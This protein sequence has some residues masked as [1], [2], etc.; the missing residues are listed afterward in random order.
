M[1]IL[2]RALPLLALIGLF[3]A[4]ETSLRVKRGP[5]PREPSWA[6][7]DYYYTDIYKPFFVLSSAGGAVYVSHRER[8]AAQSFPAE[9]PRDA[10]RVFVL[11]GS[12]ALSYGEPGGAQIVFRRYLAKLFPGKQIELIGCGMAGYDSYRDAI[13]QNEVLEHQPDAVV[14]M[15]GNNE[16]FTP[17]TAS[18]AAYRLTSLLRKL[19]VLRL[20]VDR[21]KAL[22]PAP[23]TIPER[24]AN[25]E[26][27]LRLM[28]GRAKEKKV[29]MIFCTLP[30]NVR[31]LPPLQSIPPFRDAD[32]FAALEELDSGDE[33][34]ASRMFGRY[35]E[36]HP[37]EP[38]G[39]Y[40]LARA[41]ERRK[42]FAQAR[43]HYLRAVDL[44]DPG[45]RCSPKRN[46][47]IRRVAK[48]TGMILADLDAAFNGIAERGLPD[49]RI[50]VDGC[51]WRREYY[52]LASWTILRSLDD[53]SRPGAAAEPAWF[54][55]ERARVLKPAFGARE[56]NEYGDE[57][58]YKAMSYAAEMDG[59]ISEGAVAL[60][61]D[62]ASRDP[63]RLDFLA[64][65][66]DHLSSAFREYPWLNDSA[67]DIRDHWPNISLQVGEAYRRRRQYAKALRYFDRVLRAGAAPDRPLLLKAMTLA[68][69]RRVPEAKACLDQ[70]S[71]ASRRP[72]EFVYWRA[73]IRGDAD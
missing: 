11:G 10:F 6:N 43:E 55:S 63:A 69:M 56:R 8:S 36:A 27:N 17:E 46:E 61:E 3:A 57:A 58:I 73:R 52:P 64:E 40:W 39:H 2:V 4:A 54:D 16:Y 48:D 22:R 26:A 65:S 72:R 51:H 29:P 37:Y 70:I 18:P 31:G 47:I 21:M 13:V 35:V 66:F 25:F 20:A 32:Y 7:F 38:F 71:A 15:S 33:F 14:L 19:W 28:A 67:G 1:R 24:L 12:V 62:A 5:P 34:L 53:A 41:L 44:D 50:F 45:E 49:G 42:L 68:A 9:K 59:R 23:P 60:L 30:A